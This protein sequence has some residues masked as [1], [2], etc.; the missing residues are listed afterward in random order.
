MTAGHGECVPEESLE[1]S[2]SLFNSL[3]LKKSLRHP[4]HSIHLVSS[5]LIHPSI[6]FLFFR[7]PTTL[8]LPH[9][10][11]SRLAAIALIPSI[12]VF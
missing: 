2:L 8:F 1:D 9:H 11:L 5:L 7:F 4:R 3:P 6:L 10:F 12:S